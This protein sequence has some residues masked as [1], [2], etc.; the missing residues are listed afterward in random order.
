MLTMVLGT[1]QSCDKVTRILP[2]EL[3][4]LRINLSNSG[5]KSLGSSKKGD[6]G[7]K[8]RRWEEKHA[9]GGRVGV[10]FFRA[11]HTH[12]NHA[13][14]KGRHVRCVTGSSP[15]QAWAT[16][17]RPPPLSGEAISPTW[18]LWSDLCSPSSST[19]ATSMFC[20]RLRASFRR[21]STTPSHTTGMGRC[22]IVLSLD[23]SLLFGPRSPCRR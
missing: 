16:P 11:P 1:A 2:L 19:P 13:L 22:A 5:Y 15:S 17:P 4:R 14:S 7:R 8:S 6:L 3:A 10:H 20:L 23:P 9:T 12:T 21:R 18:S